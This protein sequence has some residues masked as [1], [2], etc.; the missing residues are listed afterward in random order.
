MTAKEDDEEMTTTTQRT[1]GHRA[2]AWVLVVLT[3]LLLVLSAATQ[4]AD[5]ARLGPLTS[6]TLLGQSNGHGT[7]T[8]SFD[9]AAPTLHGTLT[10]C[11]RPWTVTGG[12]MEA[13]SGIVRST[14]PSSTANPSG[15]VTATVPLCFSTGPHAEAGGDLR[16]NG[17]VSF[18][19][20]LHAA[21]S[22][23]PSTAA[24]YDSTASVVRLQRISATG[25]TVTWTTLAVP[26]GNAVRHLRL[27]YL[28][29]VYTVVMNGSTT[30]YT[31]PDA[32]TR[33]AVEANQAVGIVAM[34]DTKTT[35]DNFQAYPR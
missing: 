24:V 13:T 19:V 31:V 25:S 22:G 35:F 12:T 3:L 1:A 14:T 9:V 33:S 4:R 11:S 10:T 6:T 23:R 8:A 29:G 7:L 32:T 16:P 20:L 2:A 21:T 28:N 34:N 26:G 30:T 27:V 18:G 15:L 17:G 5:A